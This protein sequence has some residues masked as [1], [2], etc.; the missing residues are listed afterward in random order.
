MTEHY[1][2]KQPQ[3]KSSPK[4][5]SFD[6]RGKTF[7]FKSD[8]GVFSKSEVDFGSRVLIEAFREPEVKGPILDVGCGYGPIGLSLASSF[9]DRQI[10]MIDVN[11]RAVE[12]AKEN[13]VINKIS[14]TTIFQSDLYEQLNEKSFASIVTNPPI[15]AGK[16]VVHAIFE[17]A[18]DYLAEQG[19]LW[20]VIQ[21]KQGAPSAKD[22]MEEIFG[23]VEVVQKNKGY[24]ILRAKKFD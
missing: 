13:A 12:L 19:E 21:K 4:S 18:Y 9:S 6:L 11:K 22:K 10:F 3:A 1:Y 23:N 8:I 15:R 5:W 16:K 2:S 17:E 20:V 14:N 7:Q 24:F